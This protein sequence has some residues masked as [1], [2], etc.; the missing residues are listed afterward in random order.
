MN[1]SILSLAIPRIAAV[2]VSLFLIEHSRAQWTATGPGPFRYDDVANWEGGAINDQITNDPGAEQTID[3]TSDRTM[4]K[5]L[6]IKQPA[7]NDRH[8]SLM[9]RARDA[10]DSTGE[11]RTLTLG[12]PIVVDLGNT[13]DVTA[14]FGD[15]KPAQSRF[16]QGSGGF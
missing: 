2:M 6:L 1:S 13:N 14:F 11:P 9:F 5:G 15:D 7:S 12:G 8:Y 3:F 10:D 4:P 16:R